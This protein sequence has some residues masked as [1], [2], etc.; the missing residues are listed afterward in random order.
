[1]TGRAHWK[2]EVVMRIAR[3]SV[4]P[5]DRQGATEKNIE[6]IVFIDGDEV[7]GYAG[8]GREEHSGEPVEGM[9]GK[10]SWRDRPRPVR[11][12]VAPR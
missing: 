6:R 11:H 12:S 2:A 1:M 3:I 8:R 5:S 10:S 7:L 4:A 9:P